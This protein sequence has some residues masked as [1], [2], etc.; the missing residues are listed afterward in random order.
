MLRPMIPMRSLTRFLLL[1]V[2]LGLLAACAPAPSGPSRGGST[3]QAQPTAAAAPARTVEVGIQVEPSGVASRA[4]VER[5]VALHTTKRAFNADLVLLDDR[6]SPH[7]YLAEALPE[8]NTDSWKVFPDGRMETTYRLRPNLSW[9][10][11]TPLTIDD[12]VFSLRVYSTP[13]LGL[14]NLPPFGS[15]EE[16]GPVD[17]RT[18]VIRWKRTYPDAGQLAH[19]SF[20][21]LPR[22]ILEQAFDD[23][24]A[25]TFANH[26][27]WTREYI[28]LGPF[29]MARWEPG[30]F[31][32]AEAFAGHALGKPGIDRLR[33][34]F[35]GDANATLAAVLS[36][37]I[38]MAFDG[39][40]E[41]RQA[42]TLKRD[43]ASNNGGQVLFHPNQWNSVRFEFRPELQTPKALGDV[44]VRKALAYGIDKKSLND[45]LFDS[46]GV[47]AD[48]MLAP[49]N[50][51]ADAVDAAIVKYPYD[52]AAS[53]RFMTE[54]G[55][56]KGADGLFTNA[57]GHFRPE[58]EYFD[59][60][61]F[62]GEGTAIA[63]G[64]RSVGFDIQEATFPF[65]QAQDNQARASF[66]G[67]FTFQTGVGEPALIGQT[68]TGIPSAQNRWTGGNR[69][70]WSN[71]GYDR[72]VDLFNQTLDRSERTRQ[73]AEMTRIYTDD[74]GS[75]SL[76]YPT[77][78][79]AH[80]AAIDGPVLAGSNALIA[81]NM[82]AWKFK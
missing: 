24:A 28:G 18:M 7:P 5:G 63:G 29:R 56:T 60:A 53:E 27:F 75:I 22:H 45:A 32:E 52:P 37:T 20:P 34:R 23:G 48:V 12:Y 1:V 8:L 51:Y 54:A 74:V 73:V 49:R 11:G 79:L 69:G 16:V 80:I 57:D 17:P 13:A 6:E 14:A 58:S 64:W 65:A 55:F 82:Y 59:V 30:A 26:P 36:G 9:H 15:I 81:W 31:I 47:L 70:G 71:A 43:W 25:D 46:E 44:R 3:D 76:W 19:Y 35:I 66:S 33:L 21:P 10:D 50:P 38:Q 42:V 67:M 4:L 40:L 2:A 78:P 68:T 77:Q 39:G 41:F 61:Q 62:T 72:L